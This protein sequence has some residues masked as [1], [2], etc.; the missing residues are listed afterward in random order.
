MI[1]MSKVNSNL[2]SNLNK[3]VFDNEVVKTQS[4]NQF[5]LENVNRGAH[6]IQVNFLDNSGKTLA[7]SKQ[8]TFYLHKASAL[9]NAN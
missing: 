6:T 5:Q 2:N 4:K 9:I 3:L 7:L 1:L 8:Q